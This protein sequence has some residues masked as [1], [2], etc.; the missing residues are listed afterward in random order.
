M[1]VDGKNLDKVKCILCGKVMSGGA[2]RIE[3]HI[4]QISGNVAAC[5]SNTG[6][7]SQV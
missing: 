5:K 1:L 3:E 7:A 2:Y 4:G 6:R